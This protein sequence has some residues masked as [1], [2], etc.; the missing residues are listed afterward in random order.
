MA[1]SPLENA[2]ATNNADDASMEADDASA[3]TAPTGTRVD[4]VAREMKEITLRFEFVVNKKEDFQLTLLRHVEVMRAFND[5]SESSEIIIY[6]NKNNKVSDFYDQKWKDSDYYTSHFVVHSG[7]KKLGMSF[8]I[9]HRIRSHM[10]L[11]TIKSDRRVFRALQANTGYLKAHQWS[12]DIW[13]TQDIGFLMHFD[14]SKHPKEHVQTTLA[15]KFKAHGIKQKDVPPYKLIHSAPN[16]KVKGEKIR[17][18]AYSIQVE[19]SHAAKMDKALKTIYKDDVKYVQHKMKGKMQIAY[20][21]AL[22]EQARFIHSIAVVTMF[23]IT[24]DMMFYLQA[25]FLAIDGVQ[26]YLP[27]KAT[28]TKGKWNLIV[29]RKQAPTIK[30]QLGEDLPTMVLDLVD[31]EARRIPAGFP[32]PSVLQPTD[33]NWHDAQSDGA[34]SYMSL[35]AQSYTSFEGD[36]TIEVD[37]TTF[38]TP[39]YATITKNN[40]EQISD[41]TTSEIGEVA[42]LRA[43]VKQLE[44]HIRQLT[45]NKP[46]HP[47]TNASQSTSSA[48]R[49]HAATETLVETEISRRMVEIESRMESEIDLRMEHSIQRAMATMMKTMRLEMSD[50]HSQDGNAGRLLPTE[51][52]TLRHDS[53]KRDRKRTP[54]KTTAGR[55]PHHRGQDLSLDNG[56]GSTYF[57]GYDNAP[58]RDPSDTRRTG[59]DIDTWA[60]SDS[61]DPDQ[62]K[63]DLFPEMV[64]PP[65][66]LTQDDGPEQRLPVPEA[67]L[68]NV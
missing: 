18:Q 56:D 31:N 62:A 57:V 46:T 7:K 3:A 14:P 24:E 28:E 43:Q 47:G 27:T 2:T 63:R 17:A 44:D 8:Y 50:T 25:H 40:S 68:K 1:E 13:K 19:S 30:Q 64:S 9:I 60:N 26:E 59:M 10:S 42:E 21:R 36:D 41:V 4:Y 39:T 22:R 38:V 45:A 23:G 20:A 34:N 54:T 15:E 33:Q 61:D 51:T 37:D 11:S 49:I 16:T 29:E 53:K 6:D 58:R 67:K 35:C 66:P 65:R 32:E 12:E 52:R 5:C 48:P 55:G